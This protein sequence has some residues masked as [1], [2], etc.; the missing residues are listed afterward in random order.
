LDKIDSLRD[1]GFAASATQ[2]CEAWQKAL[3]SPLFTAWS[4]PSPLEFSHHPNTKVSPVVGFQ[5]GT[6]SFAADPAVVNKDPE[7]KM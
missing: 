1:F 7:G 2:H 5:F 6:E 4:M 3:G